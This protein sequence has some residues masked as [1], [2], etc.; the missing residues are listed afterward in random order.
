MIKNVY[1]AFISITVPLRG[2]HNQSTFP[3]N[4]M[5]YKIHVTGI[6]QVSSYHTVNSPHYTDYLFKTVNANSLCLVS[7]SHKTHIYTP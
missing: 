6:Y 3:I 7:E 2:D 1:V 5:M 4:F